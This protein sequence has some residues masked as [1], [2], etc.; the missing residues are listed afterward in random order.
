MH[1]RCGSCRACLDA[2]P[3]DAFDAPFQLDARRC[4]SY[5]TIEHRGAIDPSLMEATDDWLFGCD[6]CQ[7]VCPWN[8]RVEPA[9][10]PAFAPLPA[11]AEIGL[12]SLLDADEARIRELTRGSPLAR[13]RPAGLLRNALVAAVH[14]GLHDEALHAAWRLDGHEDDGVRAAARWVI[15]RAETG[16]Q[17]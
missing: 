17:D 2:C 7:E 3:T 5:L 10:D 9:D 15:E 11:L 14:A 12:A 16:S 8:R 6:V 1:E 4:I 13:A